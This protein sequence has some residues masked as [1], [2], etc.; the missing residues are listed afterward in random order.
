MFRPSL[1]PARLIVTRM[2]SCSPTGGAANACS[3]VRYGLTATMPVPAALY[4][5]KRRRENGLRSKMVG[6]DVVTIALLG[7]VEFR[8]EHQQGGQVAPREVDPGFGVGPFL[9]EPRF[10]LGASVRGRAV[11]TE[12]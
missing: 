1:P 6:P 7:E 10:E 5:M 3:F 4:W 12:E 2:P 11:D 9:G 8:G